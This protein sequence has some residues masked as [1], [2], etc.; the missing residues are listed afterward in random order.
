MTTVMKRFTI[1]MILFILPTTI[2]CSRLKDYTGQRREMVENQVI[3]RGITDKKVIDA[4]LAIPREKFV[5]PQYRSKA[6]AELEVP[7][8][9]DQTLDRPYED[10]LILQ[11]LHL[12]PSDTVLEVGTGGG[13]LSALLSKIV[14]NVYTI[15]IVPIL[16]HEAQNKFKELGL[17]N[18]KAKTGDGF[19]GWPKHAPFNAIV[20][21][22]SPPEVPGPLIDQLAEGGHLILPLKSDERIQDILLYT[23][24]DGKL[25]PP[26][27]IASAIFTP[28]KGKILEQ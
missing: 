4:M 20:L 18:I 7:V 3:R 17:K 13:Y 23:K 19:L 25:S 2:Q 22:C 24:K 28:M 15:D 21:T 11:S 8:G 16:T 26:N 27:R 6:Y 14:A 9:E 1:F 12:A 5:L 10:A